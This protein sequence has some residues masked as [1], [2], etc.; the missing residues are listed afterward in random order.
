M[1][2]PTSEPTVQLEDAP[3]ERRLRADAVRN[4]ARLLEVAREAF[5]ENGAEVSLEEIAR[6]AGVGIGTL[7]RHFPTRDALLAAVFRDRI[8]GLAQFGDELLDAPDAFDAL[9]ALVRWLRAN[10][11]NAS[12]CQG[13]GGAVVIELLDGDEDASLLCSRMRAVGAQLLARA[14]AQGAVRT[15]TDIDD[16]VRLVNALVSATADA[17]D[18]TALT[19]RLFALMVDGLR[20]TS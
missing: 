10:L 4:R 14:Q 2:V 18:R 3:A 13:L 8:D 9:D 15:D 5:E 6:N 7:Y 11:T 16:L 19:D 20:T 12:A 17:D 1:D